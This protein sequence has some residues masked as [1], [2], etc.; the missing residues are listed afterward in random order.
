MP[1]YLGPS[2]AIGDDSPLT[3]DEIGFAECKEFQRKYLAGISATIEQAS[4]ARNEQWGYV[5]RV[6]YS[7]RGELGGTRAGGTLI[8][9]SSERGAPV[10][11][12]VDVPGTAADLTP[13]HP[14]SHR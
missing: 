9:W 13:R 1:K 4:F 14:G 3:G 8:C 12:L 2:F 10:D 7:T 11:F 6:I 5:V